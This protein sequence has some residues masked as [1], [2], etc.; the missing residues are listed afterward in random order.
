[1]QM[2]THLLTL[3]ML[4]ALVLIAAVPGAS[5][6]SGGPVPGTY[7]CSSYNISGGG[8]FFRHVRPL[9]LNPDGSYSI[10]GI[11][12]IAAFMYAKEFPGLRPTSLGNL[13]QRSFA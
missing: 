5:A 10:Q 11:T 8:G 1:M 3:T 4:G 9:T 6:Q 2:S 7:R 13:D 12:P